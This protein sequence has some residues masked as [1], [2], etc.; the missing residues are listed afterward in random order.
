MKIFEAFQIKD[1]GFQNRVVMA[2]MVPFGLQ[3]AKDGVMS[4]EAIRHCLL[5]VPNG[6]GLMI[7]QSL[8]VT[9][10]KTISGGAGVYSD[11]H[12][13]YLHQLTEGFHSVGTR[14]FAQLA[15]PSTGYQNG[16]SILQYTQSDLE[17]IRR[18]F[19]TAA[20]ICK[21]AGCDG[22]ELH[23]AHG[24]FLNMM[25]SSVANKRTDRYGGDIRGRL[26]LAEEIV[27]AIKAFSDE[28][29]IISYRMGW[30]E[31]LEQDVEMAQALEEI[32]IELLHVS[33]GIPSERVLNRPAG[34]P[35]NDVV[36]TGVYIKEHVGI[37]VTVVNAIRTINRG[38]ALLEEGL[39]DFV[40]YGKPFLADEAF[41]THSH[42]NSDY[43]PCLKCR[44][45]Q[46]FV[47][48]AKCPAQI[49]AKKMNPAF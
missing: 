8:S 30:N 15:Y 2:P 7:C 37:P 23:G 17:E 28:R 49:K 24:F 9:R 36:Y 42:K 26:R 25:A 39:C 16:D 31:R 40:A 12:I 5:R 19:V 21:K 43:Q 29:F 6:M 32:G 44:N 3:Q 35:Y 46:W 20:E 1:V 34:F 13:P 4:D 41:L 47:H 22:I 45:C 14:F 38:N 18:E 11:A 27:G 10:N 48:G 33:S